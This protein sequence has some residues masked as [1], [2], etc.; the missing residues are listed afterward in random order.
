MN[1]KRPSKALFGAAPVD[2]S[3]CMESNSGA[4]KRK[5]L[6][7]CKASK[8]A[9]FCARSTFYLPYGSESTMAINNSRQ[10]INNVRQ[11]RPGAVDAQMSNH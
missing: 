5:D 7:H 10:A 2:L 3:Y 8:R 1:L 6:I 11:P 4:R 9:L